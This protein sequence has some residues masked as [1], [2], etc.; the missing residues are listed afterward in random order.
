MNIKYTYQQHDTI[1]LLL[2]IHTKYNIPEIIHI[3]NEPNIT[4]LNTISNTLKYIP[5]ELLIAYLY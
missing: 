1:N 3:H 4:G 2:G 5:M